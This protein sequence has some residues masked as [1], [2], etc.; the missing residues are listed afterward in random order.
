[1]EPDSARRAGAAFEIAARAERLFTAIEHAEGRATSRAEWPI[2]GCRDAAGYLVT[3]TD[4]SR[5]GLLALVVDQ[6]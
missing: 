1:M 6:A 5:N 2:L 3:E 4:P